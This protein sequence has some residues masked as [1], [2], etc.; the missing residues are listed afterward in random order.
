VRPADIERAEQA[1]P[2]ADMVAAAVSAAVAEDFRFPS[3]VLESKP[4][5]S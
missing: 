4:T 2:M 1:L 3:A 5:F